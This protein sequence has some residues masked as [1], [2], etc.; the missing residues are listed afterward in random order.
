MKNIL[1]FLT[2]SLENEAQD[3]QPF[4][5]I[6]DDEVIRV[7]EEAI[8]V[9]NVLRECAKGLKTLA[10]E[11]QKQGNEVTC[12]FVMYSILFYDLNGGEGIYV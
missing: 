9:G 2:A 12:P 6:V 5:V 7:A 8:Q 11:H 1:V 3:R 10:E 4:D